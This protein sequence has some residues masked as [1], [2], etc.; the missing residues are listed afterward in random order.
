MP[1]TTSPLL[2][3][4][5]LT[6]VFLPEMAA[7]KSKTSSTNGAS[8]KVKPA[9]I[10]TSDGSSVNGS[11]SPAPAPATPVEA[12]FEYATYGPGRPEKAIYDKEQEQIKVQI[13]ALQAK[14]VRVLD[15]GCSAVF[16]R[17]VPPWVVCCEG[18]DQLR[19]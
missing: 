3:P 11:A 15:P 7:A 18:E 13:D 17:R 10:S 14:V 4:T 2:P 9:A 19:Y 5:P 8:K 1:A 6:L 16:S 12:P